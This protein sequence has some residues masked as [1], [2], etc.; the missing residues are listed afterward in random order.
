MKQ[1]VLLCAALFLSVALSAPAITVA[2]PAEK[3]VF[4][5]LNQEREKAGLPALEWN[6]LAADAARKHAALLAENAELSH[7]FAGEASLAERLGATGLRFTGSAENIARTE[8]LEDVHLALM[9]SP[10]HRAN[11]LSPKYNAVGIGMVERDGRVYVAQDFVFQVPVYT[12]A[13][14][15]A[16]FAEEFNSARK[17]HGAREIEAHADPYLHELACATDGDATKLA[18][19][20]SGRYLVV[21]NSSEPRRLPE[22][23]VNAAANPNYRRMTFGA[24]F[25]PDKEH[26]Y[27]NFWVVAAFGS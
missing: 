19:G 8:H 24:C 21:F 27:G 12:E 18:G 17:A 16:A 15:D 4:D 5:Q 7:Q 11:M 1:F 25:R 10:G 2:S 22:K 14:F 26:G 9:G 23:L 13:D 20:I 3:Q 6:P